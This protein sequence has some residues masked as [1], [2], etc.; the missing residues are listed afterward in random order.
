MRLHHLFLRIQRI[1]YRY[2]RLGRVFATGHAYERRL[3]AFLLKMK[4]RDKIENEVGVGMAGGWGVQ[5][6]PLKYPKLY[7][8]CY[9]ITNG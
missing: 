8:R 1:P 4:G 2:A 9:Y 7:L 6:V 5:E 3:K